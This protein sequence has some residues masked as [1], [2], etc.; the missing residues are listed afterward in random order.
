[1]GKF[2]RGGGML[3]GVQSWISNTASSIRDRVVGVAPVTAPVLSDED[4]TKTVTTLG[5]RKPA[6]EG[7]GRTLTGGRLRTRRFKKSAKKTHKRR[8]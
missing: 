6:P 7:A 1:M 3:D 5:G 2:K 8:H 4:T